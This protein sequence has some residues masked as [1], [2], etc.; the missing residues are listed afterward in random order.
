MITIGDIVRRKSDAQEAEI[1]NSIA[2]GL[3]TVTYKYNNR[4]IH[5]IWHEDEFIILSNKINT[6]IQDLDSGNF[7]L[8]KGMTISGSW[9]HVPWGSFSDGYYI[10]G[11]GVDWPQSEKKPEVKCECGQASVSS[12][13][14][15]DPKSHAS[16]CPVFKDDK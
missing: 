16:Y 2:C 7:L 14:G 1:I 9:T 4:N 11:D 10:D 15:D 12:N 3:Y 13:W 8:P 6:K 5:Q